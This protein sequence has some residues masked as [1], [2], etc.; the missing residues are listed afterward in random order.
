MRN[1]D[2]YPKSTQHITLFRLTLLFCW[3]IYSGPEN[4]LAAPHIK[5]VNRWVTEATWQWSARITEPPYKLSR[6]NINATISLEVE[7]LDYEN[8]V[9]YP[10]LPINTQV[11]HCLPEDLEIQIESQQKR[12]FTLPARLEIFRDFLTSEYQQMADRDRIASRDFDYT[13]KYPQQVVKSKLLGFVQGIPLTV[14][15]IYPY[16]LLTGGKRVQYYHDFTVKVHIKANAQLLSSPELSNGLV[17]KSLQTGPGILRKYLSPQLAK[18]IRNPLVNIPAVKIGVV[19]DGIYRIYKRTLQDSGAG[20]KNIDPRTLQLFNRGKEVPIV[21]AGESDGSF[22]NDDYI[23]FIGQR[24]RNPVADYAYDPFTDCNVYWLIGG[25]K[26]GLRYAEESAKAT[27]APEDA[28]IPIDYQYTAHIEENNVFIKLGQVDVDQPTHTRDHWFFDS[29]IRGGTTQDYFF[30]LPYPNSRSTREFNLEVGM[31]GLTYQTTDHEI[32]LY[33]NDYLAAQDGWPGQNAYTIRNQGQQT[34]QNRYLEHGENKL[35]VA[36]SGSA[37]GNTYDKVLLDWIRIRYHRL[38]RG[39]HGF[40]DF[41]PPDN[42]PQG[43]YHFYIDNFRSTDISVYKLG[44]SRLMDFD[45]QYNRS[46]DNYT[47][48]LEDYI[49]HDSVTYFAADRQGMHTPAFIH[50]DTI[51]DLTRLKQGNFILVTPDKWYHQLYKLTEFYQKQGLDPVRV[52]IEDIYNYC[53]YGMVSPYALKR[54]L[55]Y[56]FEHWHPGVQYVMLIGDVGEKGTSHTVPAFYYQSYK[57]GACVSDY[58]YSLVGPDEALPQFALGRW[59][60]SNRK[61]LNILI[62]KRVNY[63]KTV[64]P[65]RKELLFIAGYEAAFKNQSENIIRRQIRNDFGINRIYIDPTSRNTVFFGGSDTLI[66]LFNQG[67]I[68][69]NFFGHGGGAVWA[70]RNLFNNDH[71]PLLDNFDHLPFL[72]SMTCFTGDFANPKGLGKNMILANNGGAIGLWGSSS[73][74][75]I[76]NDYLLVKPFYDEVFKV[77]MSVGE[78]VQLAKIK[79]LVHNHYFDY[80]ENSLTYPYNLIG[81]PTVKLPL[82]G[83]KLDLKIDKEVPQAGETIRLSGRIPFSKGGAFI[84]LY[85]LNRYPIFNTPVRITFNAQQFSHTLDLPSDLSPGEAYLNYY[86]CDK[87]QNTD[88]WGATLF[89]IKGLNFYEFSSSP[90]KPR[91]KDPLQVFIKVDLHDLQSL[92]CLLDTVN[93]YEYL[94]DSGIEHTVSFQDPDQVDTLTM[95]PK[96]DTPYTWQ[97]TN[98]IIVK[99]AGKLV[100]IRFV[101]FDCDGNQVASQIYSLRTR[102]QGDLYT[103]RIDQDGGDYPAISLYVNYTG[104][105]TIQIT[106]RINRSDGTLFGQ[107]KSVFYPKQ[108]K[109]VKIPGILGREWETFHIELD[110]EHAYQESC[111]NNNVFTD[112]LYISCFPLLPEYGTSYNGTSH[113]TIRYNQDFSLAIAPSYINDTCVLLV[114]TDTLDKVNNQPEFDLIPNTDNQCLIGYKVRLTNITESDKFEMFTAI[115]LAQISNSDS[116]DLYIGRWDSF[117]NIWIRENSV[118]YQNQLRAHPNGVGKFCMITCTDNTPPQLEMNLEGQRFFQDSYVSEK[119][120][121]SL[122]AEDQNGLCFNRRGVEILLDDQIVPFS[123][124]SFADT[125]ADGNYISAQFRPTLNKG[126]HVLEVL[127]SDAAGNQVRKRIDF[128]VS[129]ELQLIDYGNYPNPFRNRTTF[130]YELTQRVEVFKIKIYTVSGRQIKELDVYS[131]P[132]TGLDINEG[133]YHEITWDGLDS[134]GNFIGNGVYFYKIYARKDDKVVTS[135][136]KIAKTR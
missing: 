53:N 8:R 89:S 79:Y 34:L 66:H 76:K 119:P 2:I 63:G 54:F 90:A 102:Q 38:Y 71:I 24:Y 60:C 83:Q 72:T 29:G 115:N 30:K 74:G 52:S 100:A 128:I 51:P 106:N 23:E 126:E 129:N 48:I 132:T 91:H 103:V 116:I 64:G 85:D 107:K 127:L 130:I 37:P 13:K 109:V 21:V 16:Q 40:I 108:N 27:I 111:E 55:R 9:G 117:L 11:M 43:T 123:A 131:V 120:N 101:A 26:H 6:S 124:L 96:N 134:Q 22:D 45:L 112:S 118:R 3:F 84:N 104:E 4:L 135:M 69:T 113:D 33:I 61:E 62:D 57:Y 75:W 114:D 59:P 67:L 110:C 88:G 78:A 32:T 95:E 77:G 125:I 50:R 5:I 68:L 93:A 56:A 122:I 12:I 133:G 47:L 81:D 41:R 19:T 94:D 14:V 20:L 98:P 18:T 35:Q 121:I 46:T 73:V 42:Y 65:W 28:I 136:G 7:G 31:H 39:H 97:L 99:E 80:L 1:H 17:F 86:M 58:W 92:V 105:D 36:V 49:H 15:Y 25:Q 70:D 82:P 87:E 10:N 44:K